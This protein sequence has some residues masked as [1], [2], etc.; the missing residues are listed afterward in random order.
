MDPLDG[1]GVEVGP[2][3]VLEG[4]VH[5]RRGRRKKINIRGR[6]KEVGAVVPAKDLSLILPEAVGSIGVMTRA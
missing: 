6:K 5:S 2:S 3:G 4:M 1:E